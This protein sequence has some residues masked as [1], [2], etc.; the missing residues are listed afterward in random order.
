[1][2]EVETSGRHRSSRSQRSG[3]ESAILALWVLVILLLLAGMAYMVIR[4]ATSEDS[5]DAVK[6]TALKKKN[7]DAN[8]APSEPVPP[9]LSAG[10]PAI[11]DF[12]FVPHGVSFSSSPSDPASP[13]IVQILTVPTFTG[14]SAGWGATGNDHRGHV[15]LGVSTRLKGD[16]HLI[17]FNPVSQKLTDHGSVRDQLA[18]LG[19]WKEGMSQNKIHSRIEQGPDG[20]LYLT[21]M[22]DREEAAA[23]TVKP[24][25]GSHLWRVSPMTGGTWEHLATVRESLIAVSCG[26]KMVYALGFP[27]HVVH[28]Y[29]TQSGAMR[30]VTVG[31][32]Q[33]HVSRNFYADA[34][35][36]VFVPRVAWSDGS[37]KS[38]S[39]SLV[40][41]DANLKEI[42][43]TP[44][45]HYA[46]GDAA[47]SHG[48]VGLTPLD[49]GSAVIITH[50][51]MLHRID[52]PADATSN[53]PATVTSLGFLHP[54]GS[55]YIASL[56]SYDG[57]SHIMGVS[58]QGEGFEWI[59]FNLQSRTAQKRPLMIAYPDR[60]SVVK[61]L[62]YGSITR[63]RTGAFFVVGTDQHLDRPVVLRLIPPG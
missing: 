51:G 24:S 57:K 50:G 44:L 6:N 8:P 28:Q 2:S 62:L 20:Y 10:G 43:S 36:H 15:W 37:K 56:F 52:P 29:D 22:D 12:N 60:R 53:A 38:I 63:D 19:L 45:A 18:R 41:F 1:M 46:T 27:G 21:S 55:R 5:P 34:R 33:G 31:T 30:S 48:I 3:I 14:H 9:P 25:R 32:V 49:G 13:P 16:A 17:E 23:G 54:Q 42:A 39:T 11:S 47:N 59:T 35:N 7:V 61:H 58:Q 4:I 40:E 26:G